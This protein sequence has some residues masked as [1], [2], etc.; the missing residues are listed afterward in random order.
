MI[1]KI[2]KG[3]GAHESYKN[4]VHFSTYSDSGHKLGF[5]YYPVESPEST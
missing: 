2:A 3:G 4:V 5:V 1:N